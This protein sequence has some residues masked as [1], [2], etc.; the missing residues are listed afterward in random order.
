[1]R[2]KLTFSA[3][4]TKFEN[5]YQRI[6]PKVKPSLNIVT[7]EFWLLLQPFQSI[8]IHKTHIPRLLFFADEKQ[9]L[10]LN[11]THP[12]VGIDQDQKSKRLTKITFALKAFEDKEL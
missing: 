8:L 9:R 5:L 3:K 12:I 11:R 1:L 4:L 6:S 10:Y 2:L 7:E